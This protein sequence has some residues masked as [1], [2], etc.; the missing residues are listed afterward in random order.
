MMHWMQINI[1]HEVRTAITLFYPPVKTTQALLKTH[2]SLW[3]KFIGNNC[4]IIRISLIAII[5]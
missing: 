3:D 1:N 4:G 5:R 2:A